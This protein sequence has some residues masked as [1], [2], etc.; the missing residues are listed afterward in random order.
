MGTPSVT[1][2]GAEVALLAGIIAGALPS[3]DDS[4]FE[5]ADLLLD[6]AMAALP[7]PLAPE[8]DAQIARLRLTPRERFWAR[9]TEKI[10]PGIA[11]DVIGASVATGIGAARA[12]LLLE[13]LHG[14]QPTLLRVD[15]QHWTIK[16]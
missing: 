10:A 14:R 4:D 1:Y 11:F 12:W 16:P 2:T 8:L 5:V 9:L 7:R 6:K 3:L 13:E 15:D